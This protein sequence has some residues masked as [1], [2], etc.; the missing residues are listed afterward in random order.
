MAFLITRQVSLSS[1]GLLSRNNCRGWWGGKVEAI[2]CQMELE[3]QGKLDR[4]LFKTCIYTHT[5]HYLKYILLE[6]A[7]M[8][9]LLFIMINRFKY[10]PWIFKEESS[11]CRRAIIQSQYHTPHTSLFLIKTCWLNAMSFPKLSSWFV[12]HFL[13]GGLN[14]TILHDVGCTFNP[15]L[16]I[17]L[18]QYSSSH[19]A[20]WHIS[21]NAQPTT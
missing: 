12:I 19:K 13:W 10:T 7:I 11:L 8:L 6:E 9:F 18:D 14:Y 5:V 20:L 15:C 2:G 21:C 16:Y 3:W 1:L 4:Q 17:C